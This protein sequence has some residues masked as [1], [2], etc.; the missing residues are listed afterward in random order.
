MFIR[1]HFSFAALVVLCAGFVVSCARSKPQPVV[2]PPAFYEHRVAYLGE[3]LSGIAKWYTGDVQNYKKIEEANPG[4]HPSRMVIGTS[5]RIPEALLI[6]HDPLPKEAIKKGTAPAIS[7]G[8]S[9]SGNA[10]SRGAKASSQKLVIGGNSVETALDPVATAPESPSSSPSSLIPSPAPS[11]PFV[12]DGTGGVV[13]VPAAAPDATL[14]VV[15]APVGDSPTP[16]PSVT[17]QASSPTPIGVESAAA[18][19]EQRP[20]ESPPPAELSIIAPISGTLEATTAPKKR[21]LLER[22]IG[23]E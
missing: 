22:M 14:P 6:R 21:S 7:S 3:T 17:L 9:S 1:G 4:L 12:M 5:V 8:S 16:S 13:D 18:V 11:L 10:Q 15:V 23:E 19:I 20:V 2:V